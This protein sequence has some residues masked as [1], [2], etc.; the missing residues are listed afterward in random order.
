MG[1]YL[2][3]LS[4]EALEEFTK[5]IM[6]CCLFSQNRHSHV[7]LIE[8]GSFIPKKSIAYILQRKQ[9]VWFFEKKIACPIHLTE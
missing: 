9:R 4:N 1:A 7:S 8:N 2:S 3:V 5:I 6:D